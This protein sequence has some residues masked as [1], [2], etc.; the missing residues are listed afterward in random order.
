MS[1]VGDKAKDVAGSIRGFLGGTLSV[2]ATIA[3][4]AVFLAFLYWLFCL[5]FVDSYELGYD[6]NKWKGDQITLVEKQGYVQ[7]IPF[8]N[9]VHTIDLRPMQVCIAANGRVLNCK[10]VKFN[11]AGLQLFLA[12]HGRGDYQG[13][14]NAST[15]AQ[16]GGTQGCATQFCE[17]LKAYAFEGQG[18]K[19]PFLDIHK[20]TG[21][22]GK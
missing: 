7:A 3:V 6:F 20:D 18:T 1:D 8:Y 13:P 2:V 10:L 12:W 14:G 22:A 19:Y 15:H 5:K 11:P 21:E 16:Q 9:E 4:A 17:I